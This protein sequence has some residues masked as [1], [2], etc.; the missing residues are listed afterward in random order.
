M[1]TKT[2]E[3]LAVFIPTDG[4][5]RIVDLANGEHGNELETLQFAVGG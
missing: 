4:N 2:R 3:K 1:E 5:A